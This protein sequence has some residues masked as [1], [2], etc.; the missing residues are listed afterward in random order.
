MSGRG[1]RSSLAALAG[2]LAA[3]GAGEGHALTGPGSPG[4][5]ARYALILPSAPADLGAMI[6]A[7]PGGGPKTL[8]FTMDAAIRRMAL[9]TGDDGGWRTVIL[10]RP[11]AGTIATIT[12]QSSGSVAPIAVV[13]EAA[14]DASGA[15]R[16]IAPS[17]FSLTVTRNY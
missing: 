15:Y 4:A 9:P 3:C 1:I 2:P 8:A 17:S 6:V 12:L 13:I 10:G 7:V 16:S 11:P 5:A 14:A